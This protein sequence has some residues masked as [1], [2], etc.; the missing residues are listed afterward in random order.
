MHR[1]MFFIDKT[2]ISQDLSIAMAAD[3]DMADV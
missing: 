1:G 2:T 3:I